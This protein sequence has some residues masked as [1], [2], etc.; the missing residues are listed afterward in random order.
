MS[1]SLKKK[2][3]EPTARAKSHRIRKETLGTLLPE[4]E[5][6]RRERRVRRLLTLE[7]LLQLNQRVGELAAQG[8]APAPQTLQIEERALCEL[9]RL[10]WGNLLL[11]PVRQRQQQAR[12][13]EALLEQT[14]ELAQMRQRLLRRIAAILSQTWVEL[15]EG[16][17]LTDDEGLSLIRDVL[18]DYEVDCIERQREQGRALAQAYQRK[19]A[20]GKY[21]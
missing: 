14:E 9:L 6:R 21:V 1:T 10:L 20:E 2:K 16:A 7:Q 18:L 4:D 5:L 11:R 15:G 3:K 8:F 13:D 17:T 19:S 12:D